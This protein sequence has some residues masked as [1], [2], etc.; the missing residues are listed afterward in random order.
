VA[1]SIARWHTTASRLTGRDA[2]AAAETVDL[3]ATRNDSDWD[4]GPAG[5][6]LGGRSG[7]MEGQ[8]VSG[9]SRAS[10]TSRG[11]E[12]GD[13]ARYLEEACGPPPTVRQCGN[14]WCIPLNQYE[15]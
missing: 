7:A 13:T 12:N 8:Q 11:T 2:P 14:A 3:R 10:E 1:G 9:T 6:G 5:C 4:L 15:K